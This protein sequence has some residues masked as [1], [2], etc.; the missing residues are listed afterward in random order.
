MTELII[1]GSGPHA[2]EMADLVA[3]VNA[4]EPTWQ[5]RGFLVPESESDLVGT[6]LVPDHAVLGTYAD[7]TPGQRHSLPGPSAVRSRVFPHTAWLP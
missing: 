2:C 7:M 4:A 6:R 3:Q 1:L 5:L